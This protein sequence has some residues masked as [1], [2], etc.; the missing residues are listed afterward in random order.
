MGPRKE[1]KGDK[2]V[3]DDLVFPSFPSLELQFGDSEE[4]RR[5]KVRMLLSVHIIN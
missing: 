3:N 2:N 5:K 4:E 1:L